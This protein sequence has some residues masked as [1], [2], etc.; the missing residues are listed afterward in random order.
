MRLTPASLTRF[1]LV[2]PFA[3]KPVVVNGEPR[4]E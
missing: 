2:R 1:Q 4:P 3:R